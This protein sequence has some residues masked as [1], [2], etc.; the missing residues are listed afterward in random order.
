MYVLYDLS[1]EHYRRVGYGL[2]RFQRL[3]SVQRVIFHRR[4]IIVFGNI[5]LYLRTGVV[6]FQARDTRRING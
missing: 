2:V 5:L 3:R 6:R 1:R 4:S